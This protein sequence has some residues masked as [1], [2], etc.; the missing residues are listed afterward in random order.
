M[1]EQRIWSFNNLA[2]TPL[3]ER[4]WYHPSSLFFFLMLLSFI[5]IAAALSLITS[6]NALSVDT[7]HHLVRHQHIAR[8]PVVKR[9]S[10]SA[11]CKN[12]VPTSAAAPSSTSHHKSTVD[13]AHS[14]SQAPSPSQAH[15]HSQAP[16][17][18][19]A[20]PSSGNGKVGVA[21]AFDGDG[22]AIKNFLTKKVST[23]VDFFLLS[24]SFPYLFSPAYTIGPLTNYKIFMDWNSFQCYGAANKS[25]TFW[26]LSRAIMQVLF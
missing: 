4:T 11:R 21:W 20:P 15:S 19:Q 1:N 6:S 13:P 7:S 12:R 9:A 23:F 22:F 8:H 10:A 14:S 18:S 3:F 5:A 16:S 25:L 24:S 26:T 2:A 17:P